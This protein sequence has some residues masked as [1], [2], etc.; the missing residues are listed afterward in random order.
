MLHLVVWCVGAAWWYIW[1]GLVVYVENVCN[2]V[3]NTYYQVTTKLVLGPF[4]LGPALSR[5]S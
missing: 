2:H 1:G 5:I 4:D 3:P